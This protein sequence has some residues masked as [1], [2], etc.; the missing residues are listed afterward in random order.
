M[1]DSS[2]PAVLY[3]VD[4]KEEQPVTLYIVRLFPPC[5]IVW[6]YMLQVRLRIFINIAQITL[7]I[8][9]G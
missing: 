3:K 2:P 1:G 5:R 6:L 4:D 9:K 8:T 7:L